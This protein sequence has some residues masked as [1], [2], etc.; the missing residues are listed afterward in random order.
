MVP[1][2][3]GRKPRR[4]VVV[5]PFAGSLGGRLE[6]GQVILC[7]DDR[8]MPQVGGQGGQA[9]L[10]IDACAVPAQKRLRREGEPQVV[11][12]WGPTLGRPNPGRPNHLPQRVTKALA[13]VASKTPAM[14][15]H[16]QRCV[17]ITGRAELPTSREIAIEF[18]HGVSRQGQEARF[19]ELGLAQMEDLIGCLV[20]AEGEAHQFATTEARRVQDDDADSGYFAV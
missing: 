1:R 19:V 17:P 2:S 18:H 8:R 13:R 4:A 5:E 15:M 3:T 14:I 16:E 7:G 11:D 12:A 9:S 20:V 10:H 6:E